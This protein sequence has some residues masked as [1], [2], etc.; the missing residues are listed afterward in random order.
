MLEKEIILSSFTCGFEFEFFTEKSKKETAKEIE[1]LCHVKVKMP[2]EIVGLNKIK[3]TV[4][5]NEFKPTAKEWKLENDLSGGQKMLEL[6]TGPV[7]YFD[8]RIYL[9]RILNWIK[10]NG[11]TTKKTGIHINISIDNKK[12]GIPNEIRSIN[13]LK[14]CL[15]FNEDF[16]YERFP[17]RKNN[18]YAKSI[19]EIYPVNKFLFNNNS[20]LPNVEN[21]ETAGTKYYGVNFLKTDKNYLEFRY[22]GGK[23]YEKKVNS[24]LDVLEFCSMS[25]YKTLKNPDLTDANINELNYLMRKYDKVIQSFSNFDSFLVYY[26]NIKLMVDLNADK[27]IVKSFYY[28]VLRHKI[29]SLIVFCN[30]KSGLINYDRSISILQV[31]DAILENCD[32]LKKIEIINCKVNGIFYNCTFY[33]STIED[34]HIHD[35]ELIRTNIVTRSKVIDTP[36]HI[37]NEISDAYI[38]NKKNMV[39]GYLKNCIIRSGNIS[40]LA[41]TEDC[42]IIKD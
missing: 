13:R 19:K 10:L 21:Y 29:Y 30:M 2:V 18:I 42:K 16:I 11:W 27:E 1:K 3:T 38:D 15:D 32:G 24:I 5:H 33:N 40:Q 41:K 12:L 26:P 4:V 20:I 31:K 37:S 35:S 39:N 6:V 25:V 36:I 28:S 23:D 22:L 17:S 7:P 14:F 9:I 8:A 34:S